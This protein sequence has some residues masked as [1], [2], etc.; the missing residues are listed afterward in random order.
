MKH[1][2]PD[3]VRE[4]SRRKFIE[5]MGLVVAAGGGMGGVSIGLPGMLWADDDSGPIDCGPPPLAKP[6]HRRAAKAFRRCPAGH[7]LAPQ[8]EEA[9]AHAAAAG[10]QDAL[11]P[12][13]LG[14]R[15]GKRIQYR[16]WMTDP[17]D[18]MTLLSWTADKL[19][20]NYRA[21]EADFAHFSFDPRE[22]PALLFAGHNKFSSPTR[23][24]RSWPAT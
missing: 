19:G 4:V 24:A 15:D 23:S 2:D 9:P 5:R 20:I 18:V 21:I 16:D 8:R 11:G 13:P 10:R 17:A 7:A 14:H 3:G 12:V 1:I 6:Q 22:L